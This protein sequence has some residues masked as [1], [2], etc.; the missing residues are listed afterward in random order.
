LIKFSSLSELNVTVA[1][2][3][4][5]GN[6]PTFNL[7]YSYGK[8]DGDSIVNIEYSHR[9]NSNWGTT[10][11]GEK[12]IFSDK[13]PDASTDFARGFIYGAFL[14]GTV[15]ANMSVTSVSFEFGPTTS[16]GN[17]VNA[18][19]SSIQGF[20]NTTVG[21]EITGLNSGTSYHFRV[22]AINS[23]GITFGND[24][25]FITSSLAEPVTDINGNVYKT[26]SIGNQIW[27]VEN[28]KVTKYNDGSSIP[29]IVDGDLWKTINTPAYCF[30][31]NDSVN[32]NVYGALYNWYAVNTLKLC[33]TGWHIPAESE[34]QTMQDYLNGSGNG[35]G[36]LK[37][38]GT[39]HWN[40]PNSGATNYSGFTALPGG[41]RD[42]YG[43]F[44]GIGNVGYW[45][46]S[47]VG[48]GTPFHAW[49]RYLV[50]NDGTV[51]T[52]A[53]SLQFDTTLGFSV[54]CI[55]NY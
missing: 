35:G 8:F 11:Y 10:I 16:Y 5:L 26:V 52:L 23:R 14:S 6:L 43:T 39:T 30:Y 20:K 9:G 24:L 18:L 44:M 54:R 25:T 29:L 15:N 41:E 46:P 32:L 42:I 27:I 13:P 4:T 49:A 33:P 50:K 53:V 1:S 2:D 12:R 3:G 19:Q 22:K 55:K 38:T 7:N 34:W 37:E 51:R 48:V 17:T 31:N 36:N 40:S 47:T 45:W 28:L 21:V